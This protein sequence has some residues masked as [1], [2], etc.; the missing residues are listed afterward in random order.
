MTI[1]I[2][3]QA[4]GCQLVG[5]YRGVVWL[6]SGQRCCKDCQESNV[7]A[8]LMLVAGLAQHGSHGQMVLMAG[9]AQCD[10]CGQVELLAAG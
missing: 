3:A 8:S 1:L 9:S 5:Q 7:A 2:W 6:P 4:A 10:L